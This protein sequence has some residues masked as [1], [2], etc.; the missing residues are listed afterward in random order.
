MNIGIDFDN[1]IACYDKAF[2]KI[3]I[4]YGLLNENFHSF[5]KEDIKKFLYQQDSTGFLWEKLQGIIYGKEIKHATVFK[6]FKSFIKQAPPE[7]N[8]F[9]ISHKTIYAHHDDKKTLLREAATHWLERKRLFNE[10]LIKRKNIFF[11]SNL[12]EKIL[13]INNLK[14]DIFI[15]DLTT[16]LLH[17][18]LEAKIRK[19]LFR[20]EP[21]FLLEQYNSWEQI[22]CALSKN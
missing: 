10:G 18:L 8:F 2:Y 6:G 21:D 7:F 1:T 4:K 12:E 19:I 5:S 22:K 20:G 13:L 11:A 3:G 14:I 17:P 15:D 9:I 16:V